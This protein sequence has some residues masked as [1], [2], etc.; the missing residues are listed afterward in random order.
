MHKLRIGSPIKIAVK[1]RSSRESIGVLCKVRYN[2]KK[3]D[4]EE[5]FF[6]SI[7]QKYMVSVMKWHVEKVSNEVGSLSMSYSY[8]SEHQL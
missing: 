4:P 8:Q 2:E 3:H 7:L 5:K 6:D 1:A